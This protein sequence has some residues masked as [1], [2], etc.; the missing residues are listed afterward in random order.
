M[1]QADP[2]R[3]LG[4]VPERLRVP[5]ADGVALSVL[6]RNP[7]GAAR[8]VLAVHGLASNA[9][10]WDGVADELAARG[11]PVAAVDQRGHGRSDKPD[12]P[13]AGF[14]FAT[15]TDDLVAVLDAI[16]WHAPALVAGQS[17]GGN[18]VLELAARHPTRL[19]ALALIDGGTIEL[20]ARFADWPTCE[21]ALTPPNFDGTDAAAM[22][23]MLR[24]RH[25]DWPETGIAATLANVEILA[26]G[27][28]RPWLARSSH[29]AILRGLWDHHP[30]QRYPDV[31]VPVLIV[32]AGDPRG[33]AARYDTA[34]RAEIAR[35]EKGL[36]SVTVRWIDGD[37]DLHAEHPDLIADL[38]HGTAEASTFT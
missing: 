14:D 30:P 9:R 24:L 10:L 6:V 23:R 18:V 38:L 37:H 26:D 7:T 20:S 32:P 11:H 16:G 33:Q 21:V 34:K 13:D 3:R 35:A 4:P 25:P 29:L 31:R 17:W 1:S 22:E 36:G 2:D 15:L 8:P 5:V 28:V 27:T 12:G 19:S